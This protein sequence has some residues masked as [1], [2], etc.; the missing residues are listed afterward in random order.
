[1]TSVRLETQVSPFADLP[2]ARRAE[3]A[4]AAAQAFDRFKIVRRTAW[5]TPDWSVLGLHGGPLAVFYN[6]IVRTVRFDGRD[7]RVAGLNNLITLPGWTGR[8]LASRLL[9]ETTPAWFDRWDARVG[10]LLCADALVP[11]YERLCW[12]AV[13]SEVRYAQPGQP[14]QR[15]PARCMLLHPSGAQAAPDVIDL[16]GLPW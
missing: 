6:A 4:A 14:L 11:F 9:R 7:V 1:M 2:D 13:A 12:R 10:L 3:L 16:G 15:W 5:A 8:G